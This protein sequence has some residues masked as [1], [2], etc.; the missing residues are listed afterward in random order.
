MLDLVIQVHFRTI[1]CAHDGDHF[2]AAH[3]QFQ[4]GEIAGVLFGLSDHVRT[5]GQ[6]EVQ[7]AADNEAAGLG[8]GEEEQGGG[9]TD[10]VHAILFNANG[11][12]WHAESENALD[13]CGAAR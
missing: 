5:V 8:E 12:R 11:V 10:G 3:A 4:L 2:G 9:F 6:G 13:G 1:W 7:Y